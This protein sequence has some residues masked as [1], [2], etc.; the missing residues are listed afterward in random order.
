MIKKSILGRRV[1][2]LMNKHE[3]PEG[4]KRLPAEGLE[5]DVEII[6]LNQH[7]QGVGRIDGFIVFADDALPGELVR[8]VIDTVK[9]NYAVGY[10]T[11][12]LRTSADRITA[13]CSLAAS[14]GG[15]SV[16]TLKYDK[17][18]EWKRNYI[19]NLL[20]RA[21]MDNIAD[22]IVKPVIGMEHP[23]FYRAKVQIPFAGVAKN[24]KAG[25]YA[26]RSHDVVD[27]DICLIQHPVAD[28]I[29]STVR[30]FL[31]KHEIEPY[32]ELSHSGVFRHLVI[33]MGFYT[34]QVMVILVTSDTSMP[35]VEDLQIDLK[36]AIAAWNPRTADGFNNKDKIAQ[37]YEL[38]S[39]W[40][41][42]NHKKTNLI[43]GDHFQL[44]AGKSYVEEKICGLT[45]RISPRAFFQVNPLQ[46]N[47]LYKE[48]VR[49]AGLTKQDY[50]LDLYC[51][52]GSISLLLAEFA[53]DVKGVEIVEAAIEDAKVNA[54]INSVTN[55]EFV[56]AAAEKWLPEYLAEGG[57]AD[58]AIIDPPRKG[59]DPELI[60]AICDAGISRI[61]YVSCNPATLV[62]DLELLSETYT[63]VT[64]QPVDM[65]PHSD[66]IEC[67]SSLIRK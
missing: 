53:S 3:I 31:L 15:C 10:V 26:R 55:V 4:K 44:L 37:K 51:G 43:L 6:D 49:L 59:C 12:Y 67:I 40:Q 16:Q 50:V 27:G 8:L 48:V 42:V 11:K 21:R 29:R 54:K 9:K 30:N 18:L 47:V 52:T 19:I 56:C 1:Y 2:I 57:K 60:S 46:T 64:I 17:Q 61:V 66:S 23:W 38:V 7:G 58:V 32:N 62:R 14:C 25:F 41:N 36:T 33:R 39:L 35:H 20:R 5:V 45:Y 34:G 28:L 63:I 24:V 22:Q 13:P 65:F